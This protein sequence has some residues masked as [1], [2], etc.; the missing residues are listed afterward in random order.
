MGEPVVG[1]V[2]I[3]MNYRQI[4]GTAV[5]AAGR[6]Y[7]RIRRRGTVFASQRLWLLR[8]TNPAAPVRFPKLRL[9]QIWPGRRPA[10]V[11]VPAAGLVAGSAATVLVWAIVMIWRWGTGP[12]VVTVGAAGLAVAALGFVAVALGMLRE[13][14][15]SSARVAG[16][17]V[18]RCCDIERGVGVRVSHPTRIVPLVSI[19]SGLIAFGQACWWAR[20]DGISGPFPFSALDHDR[21]PAALAGSGAM[22]V[23]LVLVLFAARWRIHIELYP[24][25]ILRRNPLLD[26]R[27]RDHFLAWD[28]IAGLHTRTQHVAFYLRKG[29]TI[30]LRLT[31]PATP[32]NNRLFDRTGEFGVPAYLARC[33]ANLL[34]TLIEHL[35]HEPAARRLLAARGVPKWF[36]THHHNCP[37]PPVPVDREPAALAG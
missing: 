24:S 8:D 26:V 1:F 30:V 15:P 10:F 33:D 34:L 28:D 11:V 2:Y 7:R 5:D 35:V 19:L 3:V 36:S 32:P 13:L 21:A 31:D 20:Q 17:A 23:A 27:E 6:R 25:G 18:R 14:L 9:H 37:A 4:I 16:F 29:P 12:F 22:V